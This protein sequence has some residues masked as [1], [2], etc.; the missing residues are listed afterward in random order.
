MV[1]SGTD[2]ETG[3]YNVG[4]GNVSFLGGTQAI[5]SYSVNS[6]SFTTLRFGAPTGGPNGGNT[7][8]LQ[9][10]TLDITG[11]APEPSTL[12]LVGLGLAAMLAHRR[13]LGQKPP[14]TQRL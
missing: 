1:G 7:Y 3:F 8:S 6:G 10:V 4:A 5:D 14:R 2:Q 12:L 13:R 9:S 11:L